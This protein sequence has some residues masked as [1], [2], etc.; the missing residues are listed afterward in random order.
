M[1]H[2]GLS[3]IKVFRRDNWECKACGCHTPKAK[4]GD[5]YSSNSPE[6]DH[7]IPVSKAGPHMY[8]NLQT[9]CKRCNALKSDK[10]DRMFKVVWRFVLANQRDTGGG[11]KRLSA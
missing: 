6:C 5:V 10:D 7:V 11:V 2:I 8:S 1:V 9:L 4:V 3:R